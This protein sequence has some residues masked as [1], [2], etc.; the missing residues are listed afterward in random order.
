M[1]KLIILLI[2]ASLALAES[3][4]YD[5]LKKSWDLI[6]LQKAYDENPGI[7][8]Q[9][10]TV[11]ILDSPFNTKHPSLEGKDKELVNN[12]FDFNYNYIRPSEIPG[13]Q[14]GSHVAGII[15]GAKL[16]DREP[17]G[18]AYQG[19]YVGLAFLHNN[20]TGNLYEDMKDKNVKIINSSWA[21]GDDRY[22][23][24][25]RY[26]SGKSGYTAIEGDGMEPVSADVFFSKVLNN[27]LDDADVWVKFESA[28]Q[29][30]QLSKEK[31]ILNIVA[32]ANTGR[33]S[34]GLLGSIPAYDESIRSWIVVGAVDAAA[35]KKQDDGSLRVNT[36]VRNL[37]GK[38][39]YSSGIAQFS[40]LFKGNSLYALM[41]PGVSID[42]AN[43]FY[44]STSQNAQDVAGDKF[45]NM[46]GTS[47][48]TPMVTGVAMLVAQKYSF[49]NG[50]Q[51]ADVLLGTANDDVTF[52]KDIFVQD[53]DNGG[54][55]NII[56]VNKDV[57]M[58][59]GK[60]DRDA[61]KA[62]L[63][64]LG[65]SEDTAN[66]I[67]KNLTKDVVNPSKSP[68]SEAI[69]RLEKH[70]IIGQ[71][72]LDAQ[73]A[74]KGLGRLDANRMDRVV[75]FAGEKQAMYAIDTQGQNAE[76]S[77]DIEQRLWDEKWH[78]SDAYNSPREQMLDVKKVGL[79]KWGA[80]T[81]TLS[82]K[83]TYQ[84]VSKAMGGTLKLASTGELSGDIAAVG[85]GRFELEGKGKKD[86]YALQGGI[87][88]LKGASA[89]I[90]GKLEAQEGG[91]VLMDNGTIKGNAS[92]DSA[93]F[94]V[95]QGSVGG[96][97][98][99]SNSA[100][101]QLGSVENGANVT[102]GSLS[103]SQITL[104]SS[105]LLAGKG[106]ITGNVQNTSGVVMAGFGAGVI[107]SLGQNDLTI[108]GSYTQEKGAAL[109]IA[110]NGSTS[111][112]SNSM[113]TASSYVISGGEL[114]FVPVYSGGDSR[115]KAGE[116]IQLSLGALNDHVDKFDHIKAQESNTLHFV[117][118]K[119][120]Q[121]LSS[122]LKDD[123][124]DVGDK[125]LS[126][127]LQDI[128]S[129]DGLT[130][131]YEDYF[132]MLDVSDRA[133]YETSLH[134]LA[135]NSTLEN[136]QNI[137]TNQQN[138]MLNSVVFMA[139]PFSPEPSS[140]AS[141]Y[142]A[143][144]SA[145]GARSLRLAS[146]QGDSSDVILSEVL[147]KLQ[148]KNE[149]S[150]N[151]NYKNFASS[152]YKANTYASNI[153]FKRLLGEKFLLGGF[154]DFAYTNAGSRYTT[155]TNNVFSLGVSGIYDF[156]YLSLLALSSSGFGV[157]ENERSFILPSGVSERFSGAYNN[158][159][160]SS[161]LGIAKDFK[162]GP[163]LLKPM[164]LLS[165]NLLAQQGYKEHGNAVFAKSY[166]G[167]TYQN[168][169]SSLGLHVGYE[170]SFEH[171]IL[172]VGGFSFYNAKFAQILENSMSFSDFDGFSFTQRLKTSP[173]SF[174]GGLNA[175]WHYK[176]H[177]ISA[178]IAYEQGATH[179]NIGVS[180]KYGYRF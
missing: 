123:A 36:G 179:R 154:V 103:A 168:L 42:S 166:G 77:N 176:S 58:K 122:K 92:I 84:G 116:K 121:I 22:P 139:T 53:F 99:A 164:A 14:H 172:Y 69:I 130:Q 65:Y 6:N 26:K 72:I 24:I 175:Q 133:V 101:I 87:L 112:S 145:S 25:N 63:K 2:T 73:K 124:Y 20:Y 76:F 55:Y 37:N 44:G 32:S 126:G 13:I 34:S 178:N 147:K 149:V 153:A 157:N 89:S 105:A 134:S 129:M 88:Q 113:L 40:N 17:H 28:K 162:A 128:A 82:G 106:S 45:T 62:D 57:P 171:A 5:D 118:D 3:Q 160:F 131:G 94:Q 170:H 96:N 78:L 29:L 80:G 115:L 81:L 152:A 39:Y 95:Q 51:I 150:I 1:K 97:I 67:L 50:A 143:S 70:E 102:S 111:G 125:G 177:L 16:G 60:V 173:H 15:L 31:G 85:A 46:S 56:Y 169:G 54:A 66:N 180:A 47:Q 75:E 165:H 21:Y 19:S 104:T 141:S 71:G 148:K 7:T 167:T 120:S 163:I 23:L 161:T 155:N 83:N 98:N 100:I 59:D 49:L 79:E 27:N 117:Y 11:G 156:K 86:A 138:L 9:G 140:H 33:L 110:F 158:F 151:L 35:I 91:R 109:Q 12:D 142:S 48:A 135:E 61:V 43:A 30:M 4:Y 10:V 41:A 137:L 114:E 90:E 108:K 132:G 119:D 136:S 146:V 93:L 68:D 38:D 159:A 52:E 127:I 8:G 74:L 107:T 174:L 144:G 18:I 64:A